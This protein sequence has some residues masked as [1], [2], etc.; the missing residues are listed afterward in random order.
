MTQTATI[1]ED[2][3]HWTLA[4]QT[5]DRGRQALEQQHPGEQPQTPSRRLSPSVRMH[6]MPPEIW[7]VR[8]HRQ[9]KILGLFMVLGHEQQ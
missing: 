9:Y 1:H 2:L 6:S 3:P 8:C 5:V 4:P 7:K